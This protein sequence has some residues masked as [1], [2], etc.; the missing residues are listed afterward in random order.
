MAITFKPSIKAGLVEFS[1]KLMNRVL[2]VLY[3]ISYKNKL[4]S[5]MGLQPVNLKLSVP[6]NVKFIRIDVGLSDDAS[7]TVECLLDNDDRMILGVEPH[8]EN[9]KGLYFG[10]PKFYSVSLKECFVRKGYNFKKI[11]ELQK[12]FVVIRGAAGSSMTLVNRKFY[13]AYPDKGN[14]SLYNIQ[15]IKSTGN[16]VDK[17]FEVTEFPLS[18]LF[19]AIDSAGFSFVESLKIDTEGHELEVLKGASEHLHKVMYCRVECFKGRYSNALYINPKTQPKHIILGENGYH[20]SAT[21]II[22]YLEKYNFKLVSSAPGDYTFI[23]LGLRHL[24]TEYEIYP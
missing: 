19:D 5:F 1:C 20:D 13:S 3:S 14:S 22:S 10:T 6:E 23:N 12:K 8:P 24:L 18:L 2:R 11:P 21:A 9:I 7:H 15:S 4:G 16:V 17:E